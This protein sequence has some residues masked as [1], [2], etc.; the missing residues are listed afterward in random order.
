M[1]NSMD[2]V[3]IGAGIAG[4]SVAAHLAAGHKVA[5]L[6]MEDRP[7][8]HTTGRSAALYEP[9]YGPPIIQAL[10]RASKT[11]FDMPPDS[12]VEG[13]ILS[14]RPT[15]FIVP[16]DQEQDE[17][18]FLKHA[19]D[20]ERL[21]PSETLQ[22]VP[23]LRPEALR[24]A[25]IDRSTADIDV[26]LLHQAYLRLFRKRGGTLLT[27]AEVMQM[28][29]HRGSWLCRTKAGELAAPIVVNAA[30][31][32]GDVVAARA[33]VNPLGLVPKRRSV[34]LI[35]APEGHDI[36]HWP[37]T[38]DVGESFYFKPTG[39]TLLISPADATPSEPHDAFA[40]ELTIAEGIDRMQACTHIEVSHVQ[41]TWAGLRT[42]APDGSPVVGMDPEHPGFFW[43]VGQGGY[44][45][46]TAPA[47]SLT[48]ASLIATGTVPGAIA[49][50]GVTVEA[51]LPRRAE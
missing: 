40:D 2:I 27:G 21:S 32:W 12:F 5:L 45:I 37:A 26:D 47:L 48:A 3:V 17:L 31:A 19:K 14:P 25:H 10:S 20:V 4:A 18:K 34:A 51:L 30:G 36:R 16:N 24:C 11:W 1:S 42:F 28:S 15:L 13:N 38:A 9:N 35:P 29:A 39:G 7:G 46:Q 6:E 50:F 8:Y 49:N 44:G 43:L 41:R 33:G 23:L 22:L